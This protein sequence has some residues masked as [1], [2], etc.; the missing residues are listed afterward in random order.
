MTDSP[1]DAYDRV[2]AS[3]RKQRLRWLFS[4]SWRELARI[5][6]A[7]AFDR[8]SRRPTLRRLTA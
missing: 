2:I 7:A 3:Y 8:A 5:D 6:A 1:D 4:P